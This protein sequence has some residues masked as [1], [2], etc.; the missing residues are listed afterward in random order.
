MMVVMV[1]ATFPVV[2]D[3]IQL[4]SFVDYVLDVYSFPASLLDIREMF[5]MVIR[6]KAPEAGWEWT[7]PSQLRLTRLNRFKLRHQ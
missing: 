4:D 6:C 3:I 7:C 1:L 2:T 5:R